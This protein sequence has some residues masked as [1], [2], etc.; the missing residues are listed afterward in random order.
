MLYK[1]PIENIEALKKLPETGMGF[2]VITT[3]YER[4]TYVIWNGQ[5]ALQQKGF[6]LHYLKT[7]VNEIKNKTFSDIIALAKPK[8]LSHMMLALAEEPLSVRDLPVE[9]EGARSNQSEYVNGDELF[10]RISAF[11]DDIRIDK[12]DKCL[13]PGT[14]TTTASDALKCE[15]EKDNPVQRYALPN[16]LLIRWAFYIQPKTTDILQRGNVEANFGKKGGGREVF[17]EKGTSRRT[18]IWKKQW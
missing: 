12:V 4:E 1:L 13:L 16:E 5:L 17:F 3:L 11:E 18:F 7:I 15:V 10:V 2:Q 9:S 8:R 6:D 14:F